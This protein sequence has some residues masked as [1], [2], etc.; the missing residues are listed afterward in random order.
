MA[1]LRLASHEYKYDID[2]AEVAKIWRAGCIIRAALLADIR[3]AFSR[4]PALVNLMLDDSFSAS[5]AS[6]QQAL[7]DV[8]QT[9]VSARDPRSGAQLVA[10]VLRLVPQRAP[11]GQSHAGRSATSS[12]RTPTAAS[13]ATASFTPIGRA[14]A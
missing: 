6:G 4:N 12:A 8:V 5:L 2:L 13:I 14:I 9:A 11:A 3:A 7:R 1:L 10:G